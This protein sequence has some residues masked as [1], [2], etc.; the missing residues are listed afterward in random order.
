LN[1]LKA[2]G[3]FTMTI[4]GTNRIELANVLVGEVW[5]CSGQS[6]M[7]WPLRMTENAK[8]SIAK[9]A[10]ANLRLFTVERRG[11]PRPE[12]NV[13]FVPLPG[14]PDP[15]RANPQGI[16]LQC[17]PASVEDF[18][19][20]A[21]YFGAELQK[22]LGVPVGLI[23]TSY[24]GTPAQAWTR[25]EA[26][27]AVPELGIY[28]NQY[29]AAERGY[30]DAVNQYAAAAEAYRAAAPEAKASDKAPPAAPVDPGRNQ[31]SASTLYNA[32]IAPLVPYAIKGAIWYQ[33]ESNAFSVEEA[34]RYRILFPAMIQNWREDWKLGDFPFLF[35]Q[36]APWNG[37]SEA[38]WPE[39]WE[40]QLLVARKLPKVGMAVIADLGDEKDIHP[41]RKHP[42]G[43]RLALAAR[44]L[45]YGAD[46]EYSGP[47]YDGMTV[48]GN[49]AIV[50]F[51]HTGGGLVA[52]DGA[53]VG[54]TI[55]GPDGKFVKAEAQIDGDKVRI[56]SP[57]VSKPVAVR[58]GWENFPKP[59]LN[60]FNKE[61][62]PASP[63][64]TDG[65]DG[66]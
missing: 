65:P 3:P 55:C 50:S 40:S 1:N 12:A 21:Y 4:E 22:A 20:V 7:Q 6:N 17:T 31:G 58:Y 35:V 29:D 8:E 64:R 45:A 18:S 15:F 30:I 51:G 39:L 11:S 44:A 32:M 62:L 52:K 19:A 10:N 13:P 46:I 56:S 2:G 53:L 33:G 25:R 37:A 66:K 9:A 23:H 60:L 28:L 36:L 61:G 27:A 26:L 63:F 38:K 48:D 14:G 24:G 57:E 59:T 49:A 47:L 54:F 42:V 41:Q 5:I 43:A 34:L 16:W